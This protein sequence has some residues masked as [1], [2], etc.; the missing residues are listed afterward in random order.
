MIFA[1]TTHFGKTVSVPVEVW[2]NNKLLEEASEWDA[3]L[4][5]D[6]GEDWYA[7]MSNDL[8]YKRVR[9]VTSDVFKSY[10]NS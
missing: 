5:I 2:L 9:V 8:K 1:P 3:E 7:L 6:R 10:L 4:Y